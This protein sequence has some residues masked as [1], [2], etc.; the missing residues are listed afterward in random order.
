VFD[1]EKREPDMITLGKA[2]SGGFFPVS[3]VVGKRDCMDV[4]TP[5]THGS[6]YGGNPLGAAVAM[7]A[8]EVL[9]EEKLA[10]NAN[11][12]GQYLRDHLT[13]FSSEFG[14]IE[15][16]RGKGLLN[17]IVIDENHHTSAW[18]VCVELKNNGLLAKPTHDHIIRLALPLCISKPEIDQCLEIM[19]KTFKNVA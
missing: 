7:K 1:W 8:L 6:T 14:F 4:L 16:A 17:A 3:A 2:I 10:E 11:E 18:D 12:V 13:S 15:S 19:H 9:E 5:G